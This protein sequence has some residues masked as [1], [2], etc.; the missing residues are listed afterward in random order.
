MQEHLIKYFFIAF[1][2]IKSNF[3]YS[4]P[5]YSVDNQILELEIE[6]LRFCGVEVPANSVFPLNISIIDFAIKNSKH[7]DSSQSCQDI[8]YAFKKGLEKNLYNSK[9][10]IG[11]QSNRP[12]IYFQDFRKRLLSDSNIYMSTS[13]S[14]KNYAYNFS[15]Q[16]L[17]DEQRFDE[18]YLS[19][20]LNNHVFT[21][22]RISKWW[23]PSFNS[24]LILSNS[25]RPSPGISFSNY[26]PIALSSKYLSF[27]GPISYE[28]FLNK[29]E[30]DRHI[31]D[32]LLFGNRIS[33]QPT[34]RLNIALFRTAQLGGDGRNLDSK[35]FIDM[36]IG[37]DNYLSTDINK[38]NEPGNQLGGLDFN[39]LFLKNKNLSLY[40][41]I[42]G[43]DESG[44][45]PS[46]TFYSIGMSFSWDRLYLKK[47][48]FEYIDTGSRQINTT[49]NHSI[50]KNGYRYYGMP[51]GSA[52]DADSKVSI[53]NYYQA[54]GRN[55]NISFKLIKAS[56]NYNKNEN[57]FINDL[58]D[59]L[60][61]FEIKFAQRFLKRTYF[62]L[63][64]QYSNF[65]KVDTYDN[66]SVHTVIEY[67]W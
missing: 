64:F 17:P 63:T 65:M 14:G 19:F 12:D 47:I 46:K 67:R 38:E 18:S 66:L 1:F 29:L 6:Q 53:F 30:K 26:K 35:I 32:T 56:L 40:G 45:L 15:L 23:S 4:E 28:F 57:Y 42:A 10:I 62:N 9:N 36:L 5:W 50:Y 3:T 2:L 22:G 55:N 25:A 60:D 43:E 20:Y 13:K 41:Q 58:S 39:Y 44:Y 52:F 21:V 49:Y 54:L 11:F 24:S 27:L 37:R 59:D 16:V 61:I 51:I 34:Q 31:P 7:I 33:I 48:N 8:L